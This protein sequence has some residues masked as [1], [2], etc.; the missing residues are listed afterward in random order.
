MALF[1]SFDT[2]ESMY[3]A[4]IQAPDKEIKS[5]DMTDKIL[6]PYLLLETDTTLPEHKMR[7]L[8]NSLE[9]LPYIHEK[10]KEGYYDVILKSAGTVMILGMIHSD[11]LKAILQSSLFNDLTK[12]IR[13]DEH[14]KV[15]GNMMYAF[16]TS[17]IY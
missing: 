8:K 3:N 4:P 11:N 5:Y 14:R 7:V 1:E 13:L 16:C 15:T 12:S 9:E 2:N 6:Y 10:V 17:S